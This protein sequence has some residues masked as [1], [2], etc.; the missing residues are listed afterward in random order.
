MRADTRAP[1]STL[2]RALRRLD[3]RV[4]AVAGAELLVGVREVRLDRGGAD[5]QLGADLLVGAAPGEE[6]DDGELA[7]REE[8][9][10]VAHRQ[11]LG[12]YRREQDRRE[13][14]EGH[15]AEL[16]SLMRNS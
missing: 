3:D 1:S 10:G 13:R 16:P 9:V 12:A 5:E 2:F 7:R 4:V 15:K 6:A 11:V 14:S 8:R